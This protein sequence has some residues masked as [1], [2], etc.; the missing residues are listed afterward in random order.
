MA[1]MTQ[2]KMDFVHTSQTSQITRFE[3]MSPQT[4][5]R[6]GYITYSKLIIKQCFNSPR[7]MT[8]LQR[9]SLVCRR[10]N[11]RTGRSYV[12]FVLIRTPFPFRFPQT[13]VVQSVRI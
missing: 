6:Y 5:V 1:E 12:L 11:T 10:Y 8:S 9:E 7:P 3:S 4:A 2:S 13:S